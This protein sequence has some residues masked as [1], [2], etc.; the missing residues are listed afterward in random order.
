[1]PSGMTIPVRP[2]EPGHQTLVGHML[3]RLLERALADPRLSASFARRRY[4]AGLVVSGMSTTL[5]LRGDEVVLHDGL[6]GKLAARL[7]TDLVTLLAVAGGRSL[8]GAWLSGRVKLGGNP[9]RLLPLL[10]L[11]RPGQLP[12]A[13]RGEA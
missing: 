10:P 13:E 7:T 9:L 2:A 3:A 12:Q 6:V 1:M 8:V 11:L 5:D 4:R